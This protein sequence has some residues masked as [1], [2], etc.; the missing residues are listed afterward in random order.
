MARNS[1]ATRNGCCFW[2]LDHSSADIDFWLQL[3]R[4]SGSFERASKT[5][6]VWTGRAAWTGSAH[7]AYLPSYWLG[8]FIQQSPHYLYENCWLFS[9]HIWRLIAY[10]PCRKTSISLT[11]AALLTKT[12]SIS[13]KFVVTYISNR[14]QAVRAYT[15]IS[16][17][18]LHPVSRKTEN[19]VSWTIFL[20]LHSTRNAK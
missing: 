1:W 16:F 18:A 11:T 5:P 8:K 9:K 6:P 12:A 10:Q 20:I 2:P 19:D 4:S 13:F 14:L 3:D 17:F 7:Q 15:I